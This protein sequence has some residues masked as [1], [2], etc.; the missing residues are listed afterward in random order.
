[1]PPW[2]PETNK[3]EL[4]GLFGA[5]GYVGFVSQDLA[6]GGPSNYHS[7]T[8][9][10]QQKLRF[11]LKN[12]PKQSQLCFWVGT[13]YLGALTLGDRLGAQVEG[14]FRSAALRT[15]ASPYRH[16]QGAPGLRMPS[17]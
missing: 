2:S 17:L 15:V 16:R 5:Q 8:K 4:L 12:G 7:C 3:R 1:M 14:F 6:T 9:D 11:V 10:S 13:S